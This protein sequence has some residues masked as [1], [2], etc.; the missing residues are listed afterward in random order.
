MIKLCS[1]SLLCS[2]LLFISCKNED[3]IRQPLPSSANHNTVTPVGKN[4]KIFKD[5][6]WGCPMGCH[7]RIENFHSFVPVTTGFKVYIK[8]D[9]S[10]QWVEVVNGSQSWSKYMWTI[11]N[12]GL[13]ILEDQTE[14]PEDT[15]DIK[16]TF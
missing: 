2:L 4:E 5:L 16:I 12:K 3:S 15:P 11:Y 6:K 13:E 10:S 14:N 1:L 7:L 8:R 9:N